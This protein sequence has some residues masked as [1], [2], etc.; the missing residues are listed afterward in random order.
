MPIVSCDS[1]GW[2][3][4][5]CNYTYRE[6]LTISMLHGSVGASLMETTMA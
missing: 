4:I 5:G 6:C 3:Y 2:S 1:V